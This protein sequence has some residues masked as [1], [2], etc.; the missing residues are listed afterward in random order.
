MK[1]METI[2]KKVYKAEC[3]EVLTDGTLKNFGVIYFF[4]EPESNDSFLYENIEVKEFEFPGW[5]GV[6]WA[7]VDLTTNED[8]TFTVD[9]FC[10]NIHKESTYEW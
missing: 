8:G 5:E 9:G 2:I 7:T 10:D 1:T 3:T 4:S 6:D